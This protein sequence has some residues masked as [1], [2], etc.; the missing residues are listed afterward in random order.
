MSH[1]PTNGY[2]RIIATSPAIKRD[3]ILGDYD[4]EQAIEKAEKMAGRYTQT[5][6]YDNKGKRIHH[7]RRRTPQKSQST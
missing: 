5:S 2:F 3:C 4:K 7:V 6:V 1:K